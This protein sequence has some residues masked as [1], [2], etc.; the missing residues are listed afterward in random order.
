MKAANYPRL[1]EAIENGYELD[2][3]RYISEG[4][5]IF[6]KNLGGF[7]GFTALYFFS[8]FILAVIPF[9]GSLA[10]M[11][12]APALSVGFYLMAHR[13]QRGENPEFNYFFRGFDYLGQ[14]IV[15]YIV[16]A[17]LIFLAFSPIF[18]SAFAFAIFDTRLTDWP[19]SSDG[20]PW[21]IFLT[22][23]PIIY[24]AI[25][26]RWAPMFIIF[27]DMNFWEAMEASRKIV[28]KNFGM[29][30]LLAIIVS[31]LGSIGYVALLVGIFVTYPAA[32]CMD[33]AAFAD[34]T[35][36]LE[37]GEQQHDDITEHLVE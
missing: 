35:G 25:A 13:L 32:L 7:V 11:I 19:F 6:K 16:I 22:I 31:M 9:I 37:K 18:F 1:R 36:L 2:F 26:W 29:M 12:V 21:W 33:Y 20:F 14:L 23:L 30:L 24:L 8:M 5:D 34:V 10:A 4:I 17:F 27:Y 28:N 15:L 3:G